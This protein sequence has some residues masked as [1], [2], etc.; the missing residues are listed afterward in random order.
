M[1][2]TEGTP[3]QAERLVS[4]EVPPPADP[5]EFT[6]EEQRYY[7]VSVERFLELVRDE[8]T[9]IHTIELAANDCG[10]FLFVTVSLPGEADKPLGERSSIAIF[11][12]LGFHEFRERWI[13]QEWFW[14]EG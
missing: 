5:F 7:R 14:Y 10:E 2:N 11:Y 8:Q 3:F 1:P 9:S 12:G 13:T 4:Q 6:L